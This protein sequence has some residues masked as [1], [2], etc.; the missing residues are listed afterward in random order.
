MPFDGSNVSKTDLGSLHHYLINLGFTG[1]AS[2][3]LADHK[4]REIDR[5]PA[6][7]L[8]RHHGVLKIMNVFALC[9]MIGGVLAMSM[10][11][12][13]LIAL[14]PSI[15]LYFF[16]VF[17]LC[18]GSVLAMMV[19]AE[20]IPVRGPANWTEKRIGLREVTMR[21]PPTVAA[22]AWTIHHN[23]WTGYP[24]RTYFVFGELRQDETVLDPY[25][26]ICDQTTNEEVILAVWDGTTI[27]HSAAS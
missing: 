3:T 1:I 16:L 20:R 5:H 17:G 18:W 6:N 22:M 10:C 11:L 25:L 12:I 19:V 24:H 14:E 23:L 15:G 8:Y 13:C 21:C 7:F 27:L 26:T 9:A 2:K 4:Q